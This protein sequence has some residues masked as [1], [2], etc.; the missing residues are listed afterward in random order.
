MKEYA[1]YKGEDFLVMGTLAECAEK[2]GVLPA[3][4]YF[5]STPT[6]QRRLAKRKMTGNARVTVPLDEEDDE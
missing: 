4:V 6:Y 3:T 2:L 1:V 5:Y